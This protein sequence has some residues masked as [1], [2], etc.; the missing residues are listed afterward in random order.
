MACT[1]TS[2][3]WKT[4]EQ[5]GDIKHQVCESCGKYRNYFGD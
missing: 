5:V 4:V 2:H 1:K 3:T